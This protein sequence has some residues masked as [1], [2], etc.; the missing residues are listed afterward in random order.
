LTTVEP[1]AA[2]EPSPLRRL[3]SNLSMLTVGEL[4]AKVFTFVAFAYLARVLGPQR[5]GNL[6]F[7]LAV[8]VF[9]TLS[10]DFGSSPYGA[11]ETAKDPGRVARLLADV[12]R[13]RLMLA[14]GAY[15]LLVA[16]AL[17][18]AEPPVRGLLLIFGLSLFALPG[19]VQWVFQGLDEMRWVALGS[20]VRQ[21]IFVTGVVL[22]VRSADDLALAGVVEV[23]A[24]T[25]YALY[26]LTVLRG[27]F[28]VGRIRWRTG[29][30]G[31]SFREALPVG[32][33]ELT[34]ASTWYFAT[35]L[36]GLVLGGREVGW[37]GAAHRPVMTLHTFV[38]LYFYNLLPSLSRCVGKPLDVLR[39][40][41][42]GS[43]TI[44][45]W[46]GV[47]AALVG[48]VFAEPIIRL[49]FG[50]QY[51][52]SAAVFRILVWVLPV[53]A[54]SGHY[55]YALIAFGHQKYEFFCQAAGAASSVGAGLLLIGPLGIRGAAV[56]LVGS[57]LVNL[58]LAWVW[59]RRCIG[60]LPAFGR[61][62][63]PLAAGAAMMALYGALF[64]LGPVLAALAACAGYLIAVPALEPRIRRLVA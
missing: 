40:I 43:L 4:T 58:G 57:A 52:E 33:S 51:G 19:F 56:A 64:P 50:G 54:V 1:S 27:R 15:A 30:L 7:V 63:R 6:E 31:A 17:G 11:R 47:F 12:V 44:T 26:C 18:F 24:V 62:A 32:L 36:V 53:A 48:T 14:L 55:R 34:W 28:R 49:A 13:L 16:G 42:A 5:F 8:L 3:A 38:W 45:A 60:P 25:G 10:V 61:I 23:T 39:T 21:L 41:L 29:S 37:F 35:V 46:G 20:I 59:A 2:V 22:L 9:L